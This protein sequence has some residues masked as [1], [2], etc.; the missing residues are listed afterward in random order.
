MGKPWYMNMPLGQL[1]TYL[2]NTEI[3]FESGTRDFSDEMLADLQEAADYLS[4]VRDD[5]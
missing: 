4:E 1:E 3:A 5:R 2:T